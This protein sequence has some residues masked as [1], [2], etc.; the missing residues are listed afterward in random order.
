M[1]PFAN[2]F[3]LADDFIHISWHKDSFWDIFV[4]CFSGNFY[5]THLD[6]NYR[7]I[8]NICIAIL[9]KGLSP[10][11][12]NVFIKV[13][14]L[15]NASLLF[16]ILGK[17]NISKNRA[18]IVGLFLFH[19]AISHNF[20]WISSLSDALCSLFGLLCFYCFIIKR[21]KQTIGVLGFYILALFSKEIAITMPFL[22]VVYS[23]LK[24]KRLSKDDLKLIFLML[25]AAV[26][27]FILR[28][29]CLKTMLAGTSTSIY[30]SY[31]TSSIKAILKFFLALGLPIPFHYL[32]KFPFLLLLLIPI[33]GVLLKLLN[34]KHWKK[35]IGIFI[36]V[37][38][39]S[40]APVINV[41][42]SWYMYLPLI[43]ILI[44]ISKR[45]EN[46]N[47]YLLGSITIFFILITAQAGSNFKDAG[48]Y[49]QVLLHK[50]NKS[51]KSSFTLTAIPLGYK[52]WVPVIESGKQV[53]V[54]LK[55]LYN[56]DKQVT[57]FAQTIVDDLSNLPTTLYKTMGT[58]KTVG[59]DKK[60]NKRGLE[61]MLPSEGMNY[62]SLNNKDNEHIIKSHFGTFLG[63]KFVDRIIVNKKKII[64]K[65]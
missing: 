26:S 5:K 21:K 12:C 22:F 11:P 54:G 29:L 61:L 19:P 57:L 33:V 51:N 10:L 7:P 53:E 2:N 60:G 40:F 27:F 56:A 15:L 17:L 44:L 18:L 38:L 20:L 1:A 9:S 24:N 48:L 25:I 34:K 59:A 64:F 3:F 50:I 58:N 8:P 43:A 37:F 16:F 39:V 49:N 31:G 28:S 4:N 32:Y 55:N 30:F 62:F 41:F 6:Y 47:S 52:N 46:L 14:H 63:S 35:D 65:P 45:L 23:Y 13:V 36:F 42:M